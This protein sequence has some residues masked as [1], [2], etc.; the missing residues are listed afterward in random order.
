MAV[1]LLE[2][3]EL[4]GWEATVW[5]RWGGPL[6][7][8]LDAAA[9]RSIHQPLNR[10]RVL[11]RRNARTRSLGRLVDRWGIDRV[12]QR[13]QPDVVWCNTVVTATVAARGVATGLPTVLHAHE[14]EAWAV[15]AVRSLA[16]TELAAMVRVG[17]S[18]EAAQLLDQ[19]VPDE[20]PSAVL[21]SCIDVEAVVRAG[22]G[23]KPSDG[24]LRPV[25]VGCGTADARKGFDVFAAAAAL[26][27]GS[28]T[29]A[30]WRWIGR[31]VGLDADGI[32]LVGEVDQPAQEIAAAAVFALPSRSESFPL[33]VLEAMALGRPVVASDLPGPAEQLGGD[34]ILVPAGDPEAL[35]LAVRR[36]LRD[37]GSARQMGARAARRCAAEWGQEP[38]RVGVAD[39][40][41]RATDR[42][43]A[44]G[45]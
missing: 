19:W 18:P 25:V 9:G 32:E 21:R 22:A 11:L 4:L 7:Q 31:A 43:S 15:E 1:Q 24:D 14:H 3:F 5:H 30:R 27:T 28:G 41:E 20:P 45:R 38:F 6:A 44:H 34:G 26:S 42:T 35:A 13:E 10:F 17:C 8:E 40:L 16:P 39:V 23:P 2:A 33:V 37:P 36:L 12:L 29:D